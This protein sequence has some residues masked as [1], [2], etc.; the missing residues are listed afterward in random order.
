MEQ[1]EV[2]HAETEHPSFR[3][4]PLGKRAVLLYFKLK[5]VTVVFRAN[6]HCDLCS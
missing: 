4:K 6:L 1:R 2:S 3:E 5:K